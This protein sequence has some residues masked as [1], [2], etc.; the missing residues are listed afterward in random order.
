MLE[1]VRAERIGLEETIDY[2]RPNDTRLMWGFVAEIS[3]GSFYYTSEGGTDIYGTWTEIKIRINI[4]NVHDFQS[5]HF[6]FFINDL[7]TFKHYVL[8]MLKELGD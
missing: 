4:S 8:Q 3:D 1:I 5:K 7:E 2:F 6:N